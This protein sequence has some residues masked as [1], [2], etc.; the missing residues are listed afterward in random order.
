MYFK[1]NILLNKEDNEMPESSLVQL[2]ISLIAITFFVVGGR[3]LL[4]R[5][6]A[7]SEEAIHAKARNTI[8]YMGFNG[9]LLFLGIIVYYLCTI[10]EKLPLS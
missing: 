8:L 1:L 3:L 5:A 2:V 10:V 7:S 6:E 9:V 4:K